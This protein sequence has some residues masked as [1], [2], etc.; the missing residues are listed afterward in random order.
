MDNQ[1]LAVAALVM[2]A[3]F[4]GGVCIGK[5]SASSTD[6]VEMSENE[7]RQHQ[8]RAAEQDML[9][10]LML[11]EQRAQIRRDHKDEISRQDKL[12]LIDII[13]GVK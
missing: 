9:K 8:S 4:V 1:F 13:K 10:S 5:G 3:A 11:S 2:A 12:D 7:F 6:I